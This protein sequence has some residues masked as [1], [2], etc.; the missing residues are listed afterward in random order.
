MSLENEYMGYL[1]KPIEDASGR[2]LYEAMCDLVKDRANALPKI[3]G[4]KK[5]YYISAEFLI[6]KQL[7]KNLINLGIY[8]EMARILTSRMSKTRKKSLP[9]ETEALAD[10]PPASWIPLPLS[11]WRET[12]S[13]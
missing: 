10:W 12:V 6:G 2:E 4:G 9:W 7:G 5:V 8:D 1:K 3:R 13:V 11:A